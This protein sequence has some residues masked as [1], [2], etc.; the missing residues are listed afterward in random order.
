[1]FFITNTNSNNFLEEFEFEL[2]ALY[3]F[4]ITKNSAKEINYHFKSNHCIT[5]VGPRIVL[6]SS[7]MTF[8]LFD[9]SMKGVK[10]IYVL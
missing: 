10:F 1:M 4:N 8:F 6:N 3:T 9:L 5:I 2:M 7:K